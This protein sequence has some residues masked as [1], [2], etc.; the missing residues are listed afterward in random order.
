MTRVI[1][2]GDIRLKLGRPK[3]GKIRLK[4]ICPKNGL[5]LA[6]SVLGAW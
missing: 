5:I 4:L 2:V 1:E 6:F 3:V